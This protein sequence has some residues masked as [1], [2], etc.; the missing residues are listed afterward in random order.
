M[1]IART[2]RYRSRI[3]TSIASKTPYDTPLSLSDRPLSDTPLSISDRPLS[4]RAYPPSIDPYIG[5]YR[6]WID[7]YIGAYPFWIGTL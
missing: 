5:T 4:D 6:F 7:P 2:A 3:D 1:F